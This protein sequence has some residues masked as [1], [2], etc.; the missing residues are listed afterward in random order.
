[1]AMHPIGLPWLPLL[2]LPSRAAVG[3]CNKIITKDLSNERE[4]QSGRAREGAVWNKRRKRVEKIS[5]RGHGCK[6]ERMCEGCLVK[7]HSTRLI[8]NRRQFQSQQQLR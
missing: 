5:N 8:T 1:M 4:Q 7:L 6:G 2:L 3:E